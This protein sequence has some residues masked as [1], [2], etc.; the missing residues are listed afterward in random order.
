M[1]RFL[2]I[3]S[4]LLLSVSLFSQKPDS[5]IF[6]SKEDSIQRAKALRKKIYSGPRRASI[7]S[8]ALPGL[9]QI[10]N[11]KYW[12]VPVIYA[13][14]GGFGYLFLT[15]QKEFKTYQKN[16]RAEADDDPST[17]NEMYWLDAAQLQ[18]QKIRFRKYR[19]YCAVGFVV[20]YILNVV[21]ANVDAHLKTFD[22]SD[23]LSLTIDPWQEMYRDTRGFRT[24]IGLSLKLKLK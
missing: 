1:K 14:L 10:Y 22:V 16:L 12:K 18:T 24:S 6:L 17:V 21:D 20:M 13:G 2:S 8:A 9:G 11:K 15:N 7:M 5:T 19:D 23:D 4:F 3:L